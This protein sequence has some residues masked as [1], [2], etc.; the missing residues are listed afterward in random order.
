[1]KEKQKQLESALEQCQRRIVFLESEK[2]QMTIP[3]S[4]GTGA[5]K[6][7]FFLEEY[8]S[9]NNQN[10]EHVRRLKVYLDCFQ[11]PEFQGFL[12]KNPRHDQNL[13][14]ACQFFIDTYT[15][16]RKIECLD[17]NIKEK[18]KEKEKEAEQFK[19]DIAAF[20]KKEED[21]ENATSEQ[22]YEELRL[23]YQKTDR[24]YDLRGEIESFYRQK[25]KLQESVCYKQAQGVTQDFLAKYESLFL[26][27]I[28]ELGFFSDGEEP[29]PIPE[30]VLEV[31]ERI[32]QLLQVFHRRFTEAREVLKQ[33]EEDYL[34]YQEQVR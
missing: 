21:D 24:R 2:Q 9:R 15:V 17:S 12:E 34:T 4:R 7:Y 33:A 26:F 30:E 22:F 28:E 8:A 1:M 32:N 6:N 3:S 5:Q 10:K 25:E 11:R 19:R 14:Q 31:G 23:M 20:E 27:L 13:E 18:E 29:L 16:Y